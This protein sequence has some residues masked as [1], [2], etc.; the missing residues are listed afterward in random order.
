M[1]QN[2]NGNFADNKSK[3]ESLLLF[4]LYFGGRDGK[5]QRKW[6]GSFR[7]ECRK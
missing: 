2:R 1:S 5:N 4:L 3:G 7:T 6:T